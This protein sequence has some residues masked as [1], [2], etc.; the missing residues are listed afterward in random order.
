[1]VCWQVTL[2]KTED[3][4]P[5]Q[6]E[7]EGRLTVNGT[8]HAGA[9]PAHGLAFALSAADEDVNA[10]H[11][12]VATAPIDSS[13]KWGSGQ[14]EG[15]PSARARRPVVR[16]HISS[17]TVHGVSKIRFSA[18]RMRQNIT[19]SPRGDGSVIRTSFRNNVSAVSFWIALAEAATE[20]VLTFQYEITHHARD[21]KA[22]DTQISPVCSQPSPCSKAL[23]YAPCPP[24]TACDKPVTRS[25]RD[26]MSHCVFF[27]A[28][29]ARDY[30]MH[31]Q[32]F[33]TFRMDFSYEKAC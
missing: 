17:R 14:R 2:P 13:R 23:W 21:R 24:G 31:A 3:A 12:L 22:G 15:S 26:W 27:V 32:V 33:V 10:R 29:S 18:R 6:I 1:M 25:E 9:G 4:K 5:K 28:K 16:R 11:F 19:A 30:K 7:S 20:F 8:L